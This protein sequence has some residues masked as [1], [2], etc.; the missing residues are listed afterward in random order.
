MD[1]SV[2]RCY[3]GV[4]RH[5][6]DSHELRGLVVGMIEALPVGPARD[7]GVDDFRIAE[8]RMQKRT[9][10]LNDWDNDLEQAMKTYQEKQD[11]VVDQTL[12][13]I[14]EL[15]AKAGVHLEDFNKVDDETFN[16]LIG[17]LRSKLAI[18]VDL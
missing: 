17:N 10:A 15:I 4:H 1:C 8:E 7:A 14:S 2:F 3:F 5:D 18:I 13:D 12:R 16:T 9:T 6:A 11:A